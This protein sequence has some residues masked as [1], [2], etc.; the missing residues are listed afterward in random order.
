MD[1]DWRRQ[2]TNNR[3]HWEIS[4]VVRRKCHG[5]QK[6]GTLETE[7]RVDLGNG[8]DE[9]DN[10][11]SVKNNDGEQGIKNDC[12]MTDSCGRLVGRKDTGSGKRTDKKTEH[13][14]GC[15]GFGRTPHSSSLC[16]RSKQKHAGT[17][18][19]RQLWAQQHRLPGSRA[20]ALSCDNQKAW[21]TCPLHSYRAGVRV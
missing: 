6:V 7:N 18:R 17:A 8:I 21:T 2:S 19:G 1:E 10:T 12:P 20:S 4:L 5:F 9:L 13:F 15:V 3:I 11:L 16:A 14:L